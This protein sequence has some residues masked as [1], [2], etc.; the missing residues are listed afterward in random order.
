LGLKRIDR[1]YRAHG[2]TFALREIILAYYKYLAEL[3]HEK[4]FQYDARHKPGEVV[5][6]SGIYKCT[7]CGKSIVASQDSR[8]PA[9][10]H[11]QHAPAE[12]PIQWRLTVKAHFR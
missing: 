9:Q 7:G 6:L 5:P 11:H 2:T 3:S 10:N 4:G 1:D 8:F 12:G